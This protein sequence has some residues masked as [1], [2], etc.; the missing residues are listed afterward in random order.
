MA[1]SLLYRE[2]IGLL[3][4]KHCFLS[5]FH[6]VLHRSAPQPVANCDDAHSISVGLKTPLSYELAKEEANRMLQRSSYQK[7]I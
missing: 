2:E 4:K 6:W 5:S 7:G 1:Q 3:S